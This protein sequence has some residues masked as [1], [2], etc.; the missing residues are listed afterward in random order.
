MRDILE[1]VKWTMLEKESLLSPIACKSN[2]SVGL[3]TIINKIY[4]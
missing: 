3:R 4:R 2:E 1:D